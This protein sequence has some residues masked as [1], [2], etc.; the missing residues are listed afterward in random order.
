VKAITDEQPRVTSDPEQQPSDGPEYRVEH[1][2][3]LERQAKP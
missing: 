2:F 1:A 3:W